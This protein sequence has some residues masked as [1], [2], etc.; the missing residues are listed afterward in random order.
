M[1]ERALQVGQAPR[2]TVVHPIRPAG[3]GISL[4]QQRN[5]QFDAL[6]YKK[7]PRL[8]RARVRR[9]PR[10]DYY[11]NVLLLAGAVAGWGADIEPLAWGATAGWAVMTLQFSAKRLRR[12]TRR[13]SHIAE[14]LVTSALIPPIAVFWRFVGVVR[15]RVL[16][17]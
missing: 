7:H 2:A 3:W 17:L 12:T 8:Y 11:A 13:L 1:L 14:M 10:W 16:F 5:I 6:L 9:A 15:Y 4:K